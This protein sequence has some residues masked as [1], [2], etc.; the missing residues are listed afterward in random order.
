[1]SFTAAFTSA[2]SR[3]IYLPFLALASV[4]A[5]HRLAWSAGPLRS[6]GEECGP[7]T[8]PERRRLG[9]VSQVVLALGLAIFTVWGIRVGQER[10]TRSYA[11]KRCD[12]ATDYA[13]T[14]EELRP[15]TLDTKL[16]PALDELIRELTSRNAAA[17][18]VFVFPN[19]TLIYA[20][21]G[22]QSP[23]PYVWI[24][25][26]QSFFPGPLK[27]EARLIKALEASAPRW[28]VLW[29][30]DYGLD[31]K[32]KDFQTLFDRAD[33]MLSV[34]P[35]LRAYFLEAY[36]EDLTTERYRIMRRKGT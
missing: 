29:Q 2:A 30:A 31:T 21:L 4:A 15:F 32:R 22:C 24:H 1:M 12:F 27:D 13:L 18:G 16:G 19:L 9:T 6:V 10:C 17:E 7:E 11:L 5:V 34:L 20:S 23:S 14:T 26:G 33:L 28:L 36:E 8:S 25:P 35:D 3:E